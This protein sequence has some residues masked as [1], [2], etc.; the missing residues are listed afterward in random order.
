MHTPRT[1][2]TDV[3][4]RLA[5][6]LFAFEAT[7]SVERT[8]TGSRREGEQ[9]ERLVA[10]FWAG[11]ASYLRGRGAAATSIEGPGTR[12]WVRLA[13]HD[14]ALYL[15]ATGPLDGLTVRKERRWLDLSYDVASLVSSFPGTSHAIE[16]YAPDTGPYQGAKYP[17]MFAGRTTKF[18]DAIILEESSQLKE[19][20]LLEYKTAKSSQKRSID[21]NAHERL[22]FQI[23]QYLE[24]A[25]RYPACSMVVLANGA[26]VK[27]LNKY[28]VSFHVQAERLAAFKWF[29]LTHACT[30]SEYAR[31]L[32][33][34]FR[35]LLDGRDRE[36]G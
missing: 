14:R 13:A 21:G 34:L 19:K 25:T 26:F 17:D 4:E 24:I 10:A 33:G 18:D 32:D 1:L 20:V 5:D 9:F 11:A 35:W 29:T 27:Y 30:V 36:G 8:G 15:P 6:A 31:L 12:F 3:L 23:L 16:H 2:P 7:E 28:H 22:S